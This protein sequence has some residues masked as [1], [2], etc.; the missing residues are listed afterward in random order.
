M[1]KVYSK[2][3]SGEPE[4][5]NRLQFMTSLV[6]H[7]EGLLLQFFSSFP[8]SPWPFPRYIG[9]CGRLVIV[10]HAGTPLR[11]FYDAPW[12]DRAR[13]VLDVFD[14]VDRLQR[15]SPDW[16]IL[17]TDLHS[18]NFAVS[19]SGELVIVD[20]ED[21]LV[22]D[23][24]LKQNAG[25]TRKTRKSFKELKELADLVADDPDEYCQDIPHSD[26]MYLS[27]CILL[28]SNWENATRVGE[29][30]IGIDGNIDTSA[31]RIGALLDDPPPSIRDELETLLAR[32][33]HENSSGDRLHAIEQLRRILRQV[34]NGFED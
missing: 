24:H 18:D 26:V 16:S 23:K 11:E 34:W 27:V 14:V 25:R 5:A 9:E 30:A 33:L 10:E 7:P 31:V 22:L 6:I 17:F 3:H 15:L 4:M 20:L 2:I 12:V 21:I 32:C 8:D 29:D 1:W 19:P 13:L 28:L